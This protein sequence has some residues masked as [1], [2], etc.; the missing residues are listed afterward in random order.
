MAVKGLLQQTGLDTHETDIYLSLITLEEATAGQLSKA[1]GVPRTY[2]YRVLESLIDKG[3]VQERETRSIRRYAITDFEAAKRYIEQQQLNLYKVQQEA[4]T[5]SA[6]LENL[7]SPQVPAAVADILKDQRGREELWQ[8]LHSTITREIW[9]INPPL[10]WGDSSSFLE[11]KKWEKY[12]LKQHI[13]EKRFIHRDQELPEAKFIEEKPVDISKPG[14]TS[15]F[16][17]DQYQVQVTS[18]EPFRA[19]RIESQEMIEL[20]KELLQ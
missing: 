13:W 20:Q 16:L 2:T 7:A 10:W 3:F 15:L 12:R 14:Q 6:Q 17:I 11:V 18:W 9:V 8:L 1:S 19:L 4:Q 5:L